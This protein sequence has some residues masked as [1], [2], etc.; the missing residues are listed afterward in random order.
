MDIS[1]PG[2]C[3]PSLASCS[4]QSLF[5]SELKWTE[6]QFP[7]TEWISW[8]NEHSVITVNGKLIGV[9]SVFS[10][11][12]VLNVCRHWVEHHFYDFERD[13]QLL[14][15][16]EEFIASVRGGHLYWHPHAPAPVLPKHFY[17]PP[18]PSF[19]ERKMCF[20]SQ[21]QNQTLPL[22]S[23]HSSVHH[24]SWSLEIEPEKESI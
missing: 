4:L 20:P 19:K 10:S 12:R 2:A 22:C 24:V 1:S 11:D 17:Q 16:L 5:R 14:S 7:S 18:Q 23:K 13:E 8:M 15:Q 21:L 6:L 9:T 3:R